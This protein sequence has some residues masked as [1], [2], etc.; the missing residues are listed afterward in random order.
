MPASIEVQGLR[1]DFRLKEKPAGFGG[2]LRS[3][4]RPSYRNV[5]AV[6][7]IEFALDSG[8][9]VAFIGP[10]GA[11]KS[12][13]IKMLTG[14]LY[15]TSGEARVLGLVPW[16]QRERLAYRIGTVFGQRSQLWY[17]LP[18]LDSCELLARIYELDSVT[19]RTRL[20]S[21]VDR[22][23][24]GALLDA[25]VRKLSLGERMRCELVASLLHAPKVLFPD[26]PTVGLDVVSKQRVRDLIRS[27]NAEGGV[28]VFLTSHDAGDVEQLCERVIV[29]NEGTIIFDGSVAAL[30]RQFIHARLIELKLLEPGYS[31]ELPGVEV[32]T[33]ED[34][35][36]TLAV[37]TTVQSMEAVLSHI[38]RTA[39]VA[40]ITIEDPPMEQIIAAIYGKSG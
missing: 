26:E 6:R 11:G 37:D 16:R 28:T 20:S 27:L 29:I 19:F 33:R 22:F 30:K 8:E 15:P 18:P 31:I 3:L 5:A 14:V 9:M 2:S 7:G 17:H 13:T 1:K 34:Y 10:N 38:V 4:M 25:P 36:V 12:T 35:A 32:V 39:S 24:I 23:E 40:D 21:L